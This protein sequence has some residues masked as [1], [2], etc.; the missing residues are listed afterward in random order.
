MR[1]SHCHRDNEAD[2]HFCE[3]CGR[4]LAT[5]CHAC[6]RRLRPDARYCP[7]CGAAIGTS[8]SRPASGAA[9][10]PPRL[11]TTS[12]ADR[13]QLTVLFCDLV[14]STL[15]AGRLDPEDWRDVLAEYQR[16]AAEAVERFG[17]FVA[18]YLGDGLLV[19]FGYPQAH[20]DDPERAVRAGLAILD[21]LQG[22]NSHFAAT[23]GID[24]AVR[25]AMHTGAVVV[26]RGGGADVDVFGDTPNLAARLQ[27]VAA[28]DTVVISAATLR[29]VRGIFVTEDLGALALKGFAQPISAHRV[30]QP[31]G[32]RSRLDVPG[33]HLTRFVDRNAEFDALIERWEESRNGRGQTILIIGDAGV[34]KSRLVQAMRERLAEEPHTWLECRA[35]PY[36]QKSALHPVI[37]LVEQGL[38]FAANDTAADKI[39]TLERGLGLAG[40]SLTDTVP[41]FAELL[42]VTTTE[43]YAPSPMSP[44]RKRRE[45]LETLVAWSLTLGKLQPVLVLFEDL[46]WCDPSSLELLT[47]LIER[48]SGGRLMAVLTARPEFA[49]P[50]SPQSGLTTIELKPLSDGD[51]R[52]MITALGDDRS[53]PDAVV[54]K[55][56]ARAGGIPLYV[57]ELARMVLDSGLLAERDHRY[58]LTASI[59]EFDIPTTLQGSLTA[60]LDRLSAVKEVAQRAAVVGREFSYGLLQEVAGLDAAILRHGLARL[61]E[62]ELLFQRGQPPEA[63]YTFKHALIQDAAYQ[64]LLKRTRQTLHERIARVL[65]RGLADAATAA[66]EVIARHY[67]AAGLVDDAVRHYERAARQ[68]AE[69]SAHEEAIAHLEKA[70]ALLSTLAENAER[71]ARE[72]SLQ[73]ALGSS[74]ISMRGYG[75]ATVQAA[76]ERARSLADG[77]GNPKHLAYALLGL[78]I[79]YSN[80]AE[81]A[82]AAELAERVLQIGNETDDDEHRLLGY[83]HVAIPKVYQGEFVSALE[84]ARKAIELYD[85]VRHRSIAFRAGTDMGVTSRGLAAWASWS[86]GYPDRALAYTHEAVQLARGLG[87]PFSLAYALFFESEIHNWRRDP[88][89]LQATADEVVAIAKAQ[90]FPLWLGLGVALRSW[91][92]A[93]SGAD[94]A[95]IPEMMEGLA[96]AVSTGIQGGSPPIIGLL[97]EVQLA[98]RLHAAAMAT[99]D[100]AL[101]LSAKTEQPYWDAEL[102]RLKGQIFLRSLDGEA[103]GDGADAAE[104]ET[105]FRRALE[106]ARA[107]GAKSHELRAATSLGRQLH[108]RGEPAAARDLLAPVYDWFTEGFETRTAKEAKALLEE[109]P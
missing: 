104:A 37:E 101:A 8:E 86:L 49:C 12:E 61:V 57:E 43:A 77:L 31:S 99:V 56:V 78:A 46:H 102:Q 20:D 11:A 62:A 105:C 87:H 97:A 53:L 33:V 24:L 30:V 21:S 60:R 47:R 39:T 82:V 103:P 96:L 106:I 25:I 69:R 75:H 42:D 109:L 76:Y 18:R 91:S 95:L 71:N 17:G 108:A 64:S 85:P 72:V 13:R 59:H 70:I 19:F 7:Q 79:F 84:H 100:T 45:L 51:T 98:A 1:C 80:R 63:T 92:R 23:R 66:A 35:S 107:Q 58:E 10:S 4:S 73:V 50:W 36:T 3:A 93:A 54:E 89:A 27:E 2:A 16:I 38:A 74:T 34:G 29:L 48:S 14:G 83:A 94:P 15:L 90:G 40:F 68:A 44:E 28:P 55:I 32:V 22:L 9:E 65:E 6:G 41:L 26:G 88:R 67:D 52:E 81:H 5:S